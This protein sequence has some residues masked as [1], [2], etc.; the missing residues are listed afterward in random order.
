MAPREKC[1][2][3]ISMLHEIDSATQQ[4]S[5][6]RDLGCGGD[7][8]KRW[9]RLRSQ[10]RKDR[11]HE[12]A[13]S[14]R[15]E[16]TVES[17]QNTSGSG[18]GQLTKHGSPGFW[19]IMYRRRKKACLS[20]L[21]QPTRRGS[22][23]SRAVLVCSSEAIGGWDSAEKRF[24]RVPVQLDVGAVSTLSRTSLSTAALTLRNDSKAVSAL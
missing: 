10:I 24:C 14:E 18:Q 3:N 13:H 7:I 1:E 17:S 15:Q 8:L 21:L 6:L 12:R 2:C 9:Q 11:E 16:R 4:P 23:G 20:Y 5:F 19:S 22:A